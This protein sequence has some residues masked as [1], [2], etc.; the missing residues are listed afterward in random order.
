MILRMYSGQDALKIQKI[1]KWQKPIE[2]QLTGMAHIRPELSVAASAIFN[3]I[4]KNL[5]GVLAH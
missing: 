3:T 1:L 4:G 2:R 5:S